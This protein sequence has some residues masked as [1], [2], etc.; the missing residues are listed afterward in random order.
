MRTW[1]TGSI[2]WAGIAPASISSP[3]S[4][5]TSPKPW[6][7][8]TSR[9]RSQPSTAGPSSRAMRRTSGSTLASS[10]ASA[11]AA[12]HGQRI[13]LRQRR[14]DVDQALREVDLDRLEHRGE[15]VG[16]VGE[17]VVQG[18]AGDAGGLGDLLGPDVGVAVLGEQLAGGGDEGG[19]GGGRAVGLGAPGHGHLDIHA[20]GM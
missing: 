8:P 12:T 2:G 9:Q 13:V 14:H 18:A 20:V 17:L 7:I 1:A 15:Q 11:P 4:P 16:L 19:A 3:S 10:Q 5:V 6:R